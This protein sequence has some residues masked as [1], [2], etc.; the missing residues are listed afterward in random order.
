MNN[1]KNNWELAG[2]SMVVFAILIALFYFA[3][4][5]LAQGETI[6]ME[7]IPG[8]TGATGRNNLIGYLE[9]LYTF[10][11]AIAAILAVFMIALGAFLYV[12]TSAGNASKI[13]DA[14]KMITNAI[15]GLVLA[16]IVWLILFVVN[17][18]LIGGG[19]TLDSTESIEIPL[20]EAPACQ[21]PDGSAK[22][23]GTQSSGCKNNGNRLRH[24]W[25]GICVEPCRGI[26]NYGTD[27]RCGTDGNYICF[28]ENCELEGIVRTIGDDCGPFSDGERVGICQ[29]PGSTGICQTGW[30]RAETVGIP[31]GRGTICCVCK[32]DSD[33]MNL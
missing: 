16:L 17:P 20:S 25:N 32:E 29:V 18:D 3:D 24:C 30:T 26:A 2:K 4:N 11:I 10:G 6:Q 19:I 14:K 8:Q 33:C 5:V 12:V 15:V 9:S 27:A 21:W 1:Q 13:A 7:E 28:N 31:C 23:N 22:D